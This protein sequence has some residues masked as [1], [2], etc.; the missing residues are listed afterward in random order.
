MKGMTFF[1]GLSAGWLIARLAAGTSRSLPRRY[2]AYGISS[3]A[4]AYREGAPGLA[5]RRESDTSSL[6]P[7]SIEPVRGPVPSFSRPDRFARQA[8]GDAGADASA[9]VQPSPRAITGFS[10]GPEAE[11]AGG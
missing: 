7:D 8:A 11:T 6:S 1:A 5:L 3:S 9:P 10:A 2:P 4:G